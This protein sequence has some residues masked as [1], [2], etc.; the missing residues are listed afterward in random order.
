[1]LPTATS[2]Q[3]NSEQDVGQTERQ[4]VGEGSR[5]H[6]GSEEGETTSYCYRQPARQGSSS[7]PESVLVCSTST[8]QYALLIQANPQA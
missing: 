5:K 1:M 3:S 7:Q 6:C 2:M 8:E 4:D